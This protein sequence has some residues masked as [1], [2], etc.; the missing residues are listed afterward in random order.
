[1]HTLSAPLER[2]SQLKTPHGSLN[3]KATYTV[4]FV[5]SFTHGTPH[6]QAAVVTEHPPCGDPKK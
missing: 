6:S 4:N 2:K 5:Q 1:M 3:I